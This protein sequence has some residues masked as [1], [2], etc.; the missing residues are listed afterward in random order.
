MKTLMGN[1]KKNYIYTFLSTASFTE[2]IWMLYLAWRGMNLIEIGL[3]E[4]IFHI[5]SMLCEV[6]TGY[7]A[8]RFGRRTSRII[9]RISAFISCVLMLGANSFALF[10]ISF[11]FS[12]L[13]FNLESGAGDALVY[14]S[15]VECGR[16]EEYMKIKGKQEVCYQ[17]AR[18]FSLVAGGIVATFSYPLA[19]CLTAVLHFSNFLYAFSFKEPAVGRV[20]LRMGF[21]SHMRDSIR[22]VRE[23]KGVLRHILYFE[24]FSFLLTTL[25]FYFQNFLKSIGYMEYQIGLLLGVSAGVSIITA[26]LAYRVEKRMGERGIIL[27]A[28]PVLTILLGVIAF[29]RLE[30]IAMIVLSGVES[31]LFVVFSDYVNKQIPSQHRATILSFQAMVFSVMMIVFF[32]IVGAISEKSGFKAAFTVIAVVSF[33][34]SAVWICLALFKDKAPLAKST[35]EAP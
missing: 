28:S 21:F 6:P 27:Y 18:I 24:G 26:A 34:I 7:I 17:F 2:A 33:V 10:A 35:E 29:T 8:D 30:A 25:Y 16:E 13:S 20:E 9:G 11:V 3:L 5:T 32:P 19:Y 31:I 15:L 4:S 22:A 1:I 12:A 23:N 14:D